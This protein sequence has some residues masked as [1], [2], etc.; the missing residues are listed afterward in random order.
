MVVELIEQIKR[1]LMNV[2]SE[3]FNELIQIEDLD[4]SNL[5]KNCASLLSLK[6]IK[7][8]DIS[9][10]FISSEDIEEEEAKEICKMICTGITNEK[11]TTI[12]LVIKYGNFSYSG[13][14]NI[15]S[16]N[17]LLRLYL[18]IHDQRLTEESFYDYN[19]VLRRIRGE[20]IVLFGIFVI[21][22]Q[23]REYN[24]FFLEDI[25]EK[26]YIN[27]RNSKLQVSYKPP[28]R[29]EPQNYNEFM[30]GILSSTILSLE[31]KIR[32]ASIEKKKLSELLNNLS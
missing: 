27:P 6:E 25:A 4:R 9:L 32:S 26:L 3:L 17:N 12:Y 8:N 24:F 21:D 29:K 19:S 1:N 16:Y 15:T 30:K 20:E 18:K 13:R 28:L 31:K 5:D 2:F 14:N 23:D 11:K 7:T 22:K 10:K